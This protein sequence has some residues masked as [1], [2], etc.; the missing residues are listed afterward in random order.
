VRLVTSQ[1]SRL[2]EDQI[3]SG[4][5]FLLSQLLVTTLWAHYETYQPSINESPYVLRPEN[6]INKYILAV[7]FRFQ[8]LRAFTKLSKAIFSF[9]ML[10]RLSVR[11]EQFGT[12]GRILMKFDIEDFSKNC[13]E[14]SCSMKV[15]PHL[16]RTAIRPDPYRM[17]WNLREPTD[18]NR[19]GQ[20]T[21]LFNRAECERYWKV[22]TKIMESRICFFSITIF[23]TAPYY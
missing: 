22:R 3:W 10:F 1:S 7:S 17:L 2:R 13:R 11:M 18:R 15:W 14:N 12:T 20:C 16:H 5:H 9:F 4:L 6:K 21:A 23:V 8:F 19:L